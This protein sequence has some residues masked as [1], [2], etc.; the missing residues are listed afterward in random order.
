MLGPFRPSF[1][2]SVG[3][4]WKMP[5]RLS[6]TRK[7]RQRLRLKAVDDVIAT[8]EASGV[9]TASLSHSLSSLPSEPSMPSRDKYT[10]FSRTDPGYR[11]GLHK[12]PHW[13]KV[14]QRVNPQGF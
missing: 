8:I 1:S 2:P 6:K 5:W 9:Q 11:K 7:M 4:L 10:V 13:T 3:L 12:T 14:S